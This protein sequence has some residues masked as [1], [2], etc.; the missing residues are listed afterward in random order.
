[1]KGNVTNQGTGDY[2]KPRFKR[3]TI[4]NTEKKTCFIAVRKSIPE[5]E[6]KVSTPGTL[7]IFILCLLQKADFTMLLCVY[8]SLYIVEDSLIWA[9]FFSQAI[10]PLRVSDELPCIPSM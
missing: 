10:I 9:V 5:E 8:N 4:E 6:T 3:P 7:G 2:I 1:M